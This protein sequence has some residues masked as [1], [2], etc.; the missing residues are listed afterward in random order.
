M[1]GE[2]ERKLQFYE[3]VKIKNSYTK[4]KD[5]IWKIKKIKELLGKFVG[6][7]IKIME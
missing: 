3:L 6:P 2:I 4:I 1:D 7:C 5:Q